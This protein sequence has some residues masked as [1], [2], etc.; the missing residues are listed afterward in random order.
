MAQIEIAIAAFNFGP[1]RAQAGDILDARVPTGIAGEGLAEAGKVLWMTIETDLSREE[2]VEPGFGRKRR[3][4][5]NIA[6]LVAREG[7]SLKRIRNRMDRYQ[8]LLGLPGKDSVE[9]MITS[10]GRDGGE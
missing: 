8:P 1:G 4:R 2:L 5:I 3:R 9:L 6:S 10:R 7:I